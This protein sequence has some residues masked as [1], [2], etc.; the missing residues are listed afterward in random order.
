MSAVA[1]L[2]GTGNWGT[3]E[4]PKDFRESILFFRPAGTA[5]IF[6]L[7]SKAGKK[8]V[9]D[10]EFSWWAE[11]QNIKRFQANGALASGDTLVTVDS[12]NPT[13]TTLGA[14]YGTATHLK[15]GDLLLVEKADQA[16]YDNE[17]VR[18][19]SVLSD[20]QFTI[21]RGVGGTTPASIANDAWLLLIGSA[22]AEGTAAP[23]ATSRNPVKFYNYTQI[24]KDAYELTGT[25]DHTQARTGDPWS[26]DK[27][28]KQ[29]DHAAS[30]EHSIIFGT[31]SETT[32]TNGKPLRTMGGLRYFIPASRTTVFGSAVN[33]DSFLDAVSPVFDFDMG[34]GDTRIFMGG[35]QCL[36]ELGKVF[37]NATNSRMDLGN[38]V[39]MYGMDFREFILPKGRLLLYSHPLMSQHPIYKKAGFVLD[40]SAIKYTAL[41][42][43]DTKNYDDVQAKDE[44]V[45]RGYIQTECSL[46]VDGGGLSLA[47]LGNIAA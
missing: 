38:V 21:S 42:G 19:E 46:M 5:P 17:I 11:G 1:G 39:K 13:V 35:N 34:G 3:D 26:N 31:R 47:Y 6:G 22:Y 10:P 40:F 7:T 14:A 44:D 30:I 32:G 8:T 28:R 16:T 25:A 33:P 41:E 24:F 9:K 43:R 29:F 45:R 37:R 4:R 2:R 27:K 18:V 36:I 23:A 12:P 15:P 20:T